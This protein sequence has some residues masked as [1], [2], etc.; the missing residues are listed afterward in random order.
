[1]TENR[2]RTLHRILTIQEQLRRVAEVKL[3][4]LQKEEQ[5]LDTAQEEI[6]AA[7]N[8]DGPLH[9]LFVTSMSKALGKLATRGDQVRDLKESQAE[10]LR[11]RTGIV[12][13]AE[14]R[15]REVDQAARREVERMRLVDIIERVARR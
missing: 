13:Q 15:A 8:R 2:L 9:G 5:E 3:A 7:L 4:A 10:D 1:M 12:R 6:V 14:R 11:K